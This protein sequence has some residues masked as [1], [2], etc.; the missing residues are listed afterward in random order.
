M[1]SPPSSLR[2]AGD[3]TAGGLDEAAYHGEAH[4]GP[5]A[6]A[7]L[8]AGHPVE[9]VEE[10]LQ[11]VVGDAGAGILDGQPDRGRVELDGAH[12]E[13]RAGR[14]VLDRVLDDVGDGL[15]QEGRVHLDGG[16]LQ[17][18][19]QR[20]VTDAPSQSVERATHEVVELVDVALGD[21]CPGLDA[22]EVE[23]VG[24]EAVQVLHLAVD[25]VDATRAARR[26]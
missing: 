13:G 20:T 25:G 5:R 3:A 9:L 23:Q 11:R 14:R 21:Q 24:D 6:G 15:V 16:R 1:A 22:A 17:V 7:A 12:S 10:P 18:D 26:G 2:R 8:A 4:A 19:L